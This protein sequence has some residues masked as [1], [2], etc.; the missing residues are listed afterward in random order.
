MEKKPI[1]ILGIV[2]IELMLFF[3][4][5]ITNKS[6]MTFLNTLNNKKKILSINSDEIV[7]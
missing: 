5:Y 6:L 4:Q 2:K 1:I 3:L 7:K